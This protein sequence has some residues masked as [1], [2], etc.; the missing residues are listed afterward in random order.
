MLKKKVK[1]IAYQDIHM[2]LVIVILNFEFLSLPEK[3][4]GMSGIEAIFC[5]RKI[6]RVY[7]SV[8]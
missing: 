8:L 6:C 3:L 7:L 2:F 5:K 4:Q 1:R